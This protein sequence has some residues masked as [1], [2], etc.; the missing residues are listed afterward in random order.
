[1]SSVKVEPMSKQRTKKK[2]KEKRNQYVNTTDI[3]D[4]IVMP[5]HKH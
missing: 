1:L 2:A 4:V 5:T 3:W